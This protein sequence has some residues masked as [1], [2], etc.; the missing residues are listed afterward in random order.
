MPGSTPPASP[1]ATLDIQR[2]VA[3]AQF[4]HQ[5]VEP[6]DMG[7]PDVP[8]RH[9][10]RLAGVA[11]HVPFEKIDADFRDQGIETFQQMGHHFR[12]AKVQHQLA[13]AFGARTGRVVQHPV[14]MSPV[15][16]GVGVDHLGLHPKTK[17]HAERVDMIGQRF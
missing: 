13:A 17:G 9:R 14:G 4:V 10:T 1:G 3:A 6:A 8:A 12:A 11:V 5:V 16:V 2:R 15:E 7:A